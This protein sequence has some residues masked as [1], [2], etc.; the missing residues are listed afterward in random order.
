MLDNIK[1]KQLKEN[2]YL[3]PL[4]IFSPEEVIQNK[5]NFDALRSALGGNPGPEKL[6]QTHLYHSWVYD[7]VTDKRIVEIVKSILGPNILVHSTS[8][9]CKYAQNDGFIPWHQDGVY[10]GLESPDLWSVWLAISNS[11]SENGCMQVIPK[12]HKLKFD[13]FEQVNKKV[14][15]GSGLTIEEGRPEGE[16]VDIE[17]NAGQISLHHL[18]IA[19]ASEANKSNNDRIGLAI[20]YINTENQQTLPHFKTVLASGKDDFGHYSLL[21]Q[22][23]SNDLNSSIEEQMRCTAIYEK[24]RADF[25]KENGK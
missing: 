13:H 3:Y 20:R 19:H 10:W 18:S 6:K 17:L 7:L 4:T 16:I 2:G 22:R 15:L 9:F 23:P 5:N 14:L 25:L 21:D 24:I 1:L 11:T 12:T 8:I